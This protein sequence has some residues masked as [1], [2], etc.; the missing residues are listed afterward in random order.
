MCYSDSQASIV[1]YMR[2][3]KG[4]LQKLVGVGIVRVKLDKNWRTTFCARSRY[5]GT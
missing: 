2:R 1:D 4:E 3:T 5:D